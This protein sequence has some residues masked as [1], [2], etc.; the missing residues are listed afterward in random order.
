MGA[1][2][3]EWAEAACYSHF[4][5]GMGAR[6]CPFFLAQCVCASCADAGGAAAAAHG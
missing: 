1:V 2:L 5:S 6:E 4:A 3:L